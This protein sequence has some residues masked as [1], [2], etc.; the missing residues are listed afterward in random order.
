ME[1]AQAQEQERGVSP[2]PVGAVQAEQV[3]NI[4]NTGVAVFSAQQVCVWEEEF[5]VQA[6]KPEH[7]T[8]VEFRTRQQLKCLSHGIVQKPCRPLLL[9]LESEA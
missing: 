5:A 9:Y 3:A 4:S 7:S 8:R 1:G 2:S 6:C